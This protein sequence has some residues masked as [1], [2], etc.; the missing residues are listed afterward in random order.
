[1]IEI[2]RYNIYAFGTK[3]CQHGIQDDVYEAVCS[4]SSKYRGYIIMGIED[5]GTPIGIN[6][7]M[8]R[9]PEMPLQSAFP[10]QMEILRLNLFFLLQNIIPN[11]TND[12]RSK[13]TA[14]ADHACN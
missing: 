9:D 2:T 3:A 6:R 8:V 12:H 14:V 10:G 4:F 11:H 13:I 7:N 1:M 5:D